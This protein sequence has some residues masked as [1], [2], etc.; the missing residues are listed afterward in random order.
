M[1]QWWFDHGW[2]LL[3][4]D[5]HAV[6]LTLAAVWS[7]VYAYPR[8]VHGARRSPQAKG[9]L[10]SIP[11]FVWAIE[12]CLQA[13]NATAIDLI[14]GYTRY[15]LFWAYMVSGA[16]VGFVILGAVAGA[17]RLSQ[18]E[19]VRGFPAGG[20]AVAALSWGLVVAAWVAVFV[21]EA[22]LPI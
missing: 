12:A 3:T 10:A 11:I 5:A 6:S 22:R 8:V 9:L 19:T 16:L 15:P 17:Y 21:H 4:I 7:I 1:G 13:G 2:R 14:G 20:V 18:P